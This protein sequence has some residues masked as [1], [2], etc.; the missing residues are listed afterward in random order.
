[1]KEYKQKIATKGQLKLIIFTDLLIFIAIGVI[2]YESYKKINHFT[3]YLLLGS[4]FILMGVNQYIYYKNNGG[5]RYVILT[6][7]YS[8]IGLAMILFRLFM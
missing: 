8:L 2:I 1:M 3:S 7:L 6:S 4:V 5:I